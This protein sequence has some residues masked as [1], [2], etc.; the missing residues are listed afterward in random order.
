MSLC[1]AL[2][3]KAS[4]GLAACRVVVLFDETKIELMIPAHA[5][6]KEVKEELLKSTN[7]VPR[8][9]MLVDSHTQMELPATTTIGDI[10]SLSGKNEL[11]LHL[12]S[13][14]SNA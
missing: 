9:Q 5:T 6:L 2:I 4:K 8:E 1:V 3:E 13:P 11:E 7:I 10:I 14:N 12:L